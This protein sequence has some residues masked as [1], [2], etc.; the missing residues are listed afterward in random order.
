MLQSD[1]KV[2]QEKR[3]KTEFHTGSGVQG[4]SVW[5]FA[6]H[7]FNDI[8]LALWYVTACRREEESRKP[9]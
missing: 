5:R 6:V 2:K 8:N 3:V 9:A 1:G 4:G 7:P